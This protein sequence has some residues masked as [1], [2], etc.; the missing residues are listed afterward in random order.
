MIQSVDVRVGLMLIWLAP[1]RPE[2]RYVPERKRGLP[3]KMT[4]G[5]QK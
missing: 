3:A 2:V 5:E 4:L 1:A